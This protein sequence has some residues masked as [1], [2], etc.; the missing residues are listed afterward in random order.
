MVTNV[1]LGGLYI[2]GRHNLYC[3]DLYQNLSH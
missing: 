1:A 3:A 2:I